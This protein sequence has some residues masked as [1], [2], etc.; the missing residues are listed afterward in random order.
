[1]HGPIDREIV[2]A[3][4]A[5]GRKSVTELASHVNLSVS[6][7]SRRL[8]ELHTAGVITGYRAIVD[9][10]AVGVAFEVLAHITMQREDADTV[11]AFE[12]QLAEIPQVRHAKR[13]FGDPDYLV[14][15][16]TADINTYQQLRDTRLARLPGVEKI[17]STIVMRRVVDDQPYPIE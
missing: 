10:A 13:L 6:A 3:L 17:T 4:Q 7:C 5:D 14:R 2:A 15:V 16:A 8:H 9:P 12:Q 1:M 11:T